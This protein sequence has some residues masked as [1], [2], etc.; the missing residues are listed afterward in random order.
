MERFPFGSPVKFSSFRWIPPIS[1]LALITQNC[2]CH[3]N[4]SPPSLILLRHGYE[5]LAHRSLVAK[6][7]LSYGGQSSLACQPKPWRRLAE[8]VGI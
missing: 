8:G 7:G 3:G 1:N 6:V 2:I 4:W 5:G